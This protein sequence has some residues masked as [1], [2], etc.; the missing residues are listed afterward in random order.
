M[1]CAKWAEEGLLFASRE[2]D[3]SRKAAYLEHLRVCAPCRSEAEEYEQHRNKFFT[4]E[5]LGAEP[6]QATSN[7][8]LRVC[9]CP[10]KKI[11]SAFAFFTLFRK[12]A[13]ATVLIALGFFGAGYF[14]YMAS[15]PP[16]SNAPVVNN[17]SDHQLPALQNAAA[18]N[19]AP[20]ALAQTDSASADTLK[21]ARKG[22]PAGVTPVTM[23]KE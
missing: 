19:T 20:A 21:P 11:T 8:I 2:L 7:E 3:E 5:I 23:E 9:S 22:D 4:H 10:V 1:E 6:S 18:P 13:A 16:R 15:N 12:G 17:V 14:V